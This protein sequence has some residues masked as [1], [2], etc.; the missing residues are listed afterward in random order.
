MTATGTSEIP[1]SEAFAQDADD[2][3]GLAH[4][5]EMHCRH[6]VLQKIAALGYAP[7]STYLIDGFPVSAGSPDLRPGMIG[8]VIPA[9]RHL[10]T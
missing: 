4:G 3:F 9:S 2:V 7:V 5:I 6:T 1:L 10:A 8:T